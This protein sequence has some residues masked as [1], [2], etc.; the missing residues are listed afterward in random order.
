MAEETIVT[1]RSGNG[2]VPGSDS[3]I[4]FLEGPQNSAFA[5]A[6]VPADFASARAGSNA[7]I[8]VAHGSWKANLDSDPSAEWIGTRA[9]AV[10]DGWTG[11]YAIDFEVPS[12]LESA[13]MDFDFLVDNTLGD[14]NNEGVFINGTPIDSTKGGGFGSDTS[15]SSLDI[16][17]LLNTGTNTLYINAVDTGGPGA[18][19]F[20][21]TITIEATPP[22][23]SGGTPGIGTKTKQKNEMLPDRPTAKTRAII[24]SI[25]LT[26]S[27]VINKGQ[28]RM[29]ALSMAEG[30]VNGHLIG[31]KLL[32]K[33][34]LSLSE[35]TYASLKFQS[36]DRAKSIIGLDAWIDRQMGSL[37]KVI[38]ASSRLA[39]LQILE[40]PTILSFE[41]DEQTNN[42]ALIAFT[43]SSSFIGN[44]RYNTD[45]QGMLMLLNG[46]EYNFCNVPARI[47]DS[48][49][50]ADSKGA[51]FARSIKGQF[52]C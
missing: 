45:T 22:S 30:I 20:S 2:S 25:L 41:F 52:D 12:G 51:F 44:V 14:A 16:F 19:Q 21:A 35:K 50:G 39:Q 43:H 26:K 7:F 37:T 8:I 38:E 4:T 24:D 9:T 40:E 28:I 5:D 3:K 31:G 47:F 13:T 42:E 46:K 10:T 36:T 23:G 29:P 48:F 33:I 18:L 11:L 32:A 6:F 17:S 15:F 27:L 49:Q 1:L 34:H